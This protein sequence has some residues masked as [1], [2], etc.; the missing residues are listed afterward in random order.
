MALKT[1]FG[2]LVIFIKMN[3]GKDILLKVYLE[4][5]KH[6]FGEITGLAD[7]VSLSFS[8]TGILEKKTTLLRFYL[9]SFTLFFLCFLFIC[10]LRLGP[11][12]TI[13][14]ILPLYSTTPDLP[15]PPE[16]QDS[17][18][19]FSVTVTQAVQQKYCI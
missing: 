18:Q 4:K 9:V 6:V 13:L 8:T 2:V 14:I 12:V 15:P 10:L 1:A 7:T 5:K 3:I 16:S 11:C 17:I 19:N